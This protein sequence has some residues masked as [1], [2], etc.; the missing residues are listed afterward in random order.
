MHQS[1][2]FYGETYASRI[3][4]ERDRL[5]QIAR[6]EREAIDRV[7]RDAVPDFKGEAAA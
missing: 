1:T 7:L 4:E 6:D 2:D 5:A 3:D